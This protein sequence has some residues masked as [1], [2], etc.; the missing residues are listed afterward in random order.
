ML[1]QI[2]LFEI[3]YRLQRPATYI[4]FAI[5]FGFSFLIITLPDSSVS[6]AGEQLHKNAP[7][8]I[9]Q[10]VST[11]VLFGSVILAGVMGVPVYR[12][13]DYNFNEIVFSLPIKKWEYLLGKFT[14]SYIIA[15]IIHLGIVFGLMLGTLMPWIDKSDLGPF[16]LEAYI[17]P[18]FVFLLPNVFILGVVFFTVGALTRSQLAIYAQGLIFIV[19][20]FILSRL[21]ENVDTNPVNSVFE[22]FGSV[23]ASFETKYWTTYERNTLM[24]PFTGYVLLN[25]IVWIAFA[26]L[27]G[28]ICYL[29]FSPVPHHLFRAKKKSVTDDHRIPGRR[30]IK[31]PDFKGDY[32]LRAQIYQWWYFSRFH[33]KKTI[34]AIPFWIML[35]SGIGLLLLGRMG[36]NMLNSKSLPVTYML[37]NFLQGSFMIFTVIIIAIYSGELIW[38]DI[39]VKIS[40]VIDSTPVS[41]SL[42]V[43]SRFTAMVFVELFIIFF[44]MLTGIGIQISEGFFHFQ[45]DVYL[46]VLLLQTFPF[47]L[48]FTFLVFLVHTLINNKY[49][50]HT[51]IVALFLIQIFAG[52]FGLNHILTKYGTS[53][54]KSYSDMNR[55]YN[56]VFPELV[57]DFYWLMLGIVFLIVSVLFVK[58]G[59][60][61][62]F[63]ER[64][65]EMKIRWKTGHAKILIPIFLIMFIIS[66]SYIYYNTNILN[67]YRNKKADR[68]Y[69][70]AYERKYS[71]YK[72]YPQP[73]ILDVKLEADLY[74]KKMRCEM[75]GK[76]II[77]NKNNV[78]LDSFHVR[79]SP[80]ITINKLKFSIP[81][82]LVDSSKDYGY[83]IYKLDNPMQPGDT[84]ELAFDFIYQ[85]RGFNHWGH[86]TELVYNGT[87]LHQE[88]VPSFGYN[89]EQE[90][91][92]KKDRKKEGLPEKEF[93][94][95]EIT[96]TLA[97]KN[98]YISKN[99]DR[100]SYECIISTDPDQMAISAGDLVDEWTENGRRYFK[101]KMEEPIWN[102][103]PFFSAKYKVYKE[104]YKGLKIAVY[105]HP[106][107]DY[108]I[109]TMVKALKKTVDFCNKNYFPFQHDVLR[110]VEFPRYGGY[111]QSFASTIAFSEGLGFI[112]D[113]D[114]KRDID[115]PFFVTAHEVA[116]QWW[117]H[118]I[119]AADVKG[120]TLMVESLA[121]YT[122]LMVMLEELGEKQ[123]G[124]FL[125]YELDRYMIQRATER[126]KEPPL[127][128]VDNQNYLSYQKGG[129]AFYNLQDFIG[130]DSLHKALSRFIEK[131]YYQDAP[132][133]TSLDLI[134]F[135]KK[136]VP[137]SLNYIIDDWFMNITLYS[138][139]TDS[140]Y[141]RETEEGKYN[142]KLYTTSKK[143]QADSLGKQDALPLN[144][145]LDIGVYTKG[146]DNEDSLI[147]LKKVLVKDKNEVFTVEVNQKPTKAGIDPLNKQIDRNLLD[148]KKSVEPI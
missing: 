92:D 49:V 143:Y 81:T 19:L 138:N 112:L 146:S 78:E 3:K 44:I 66:G 53:I 76:Y 18:V 55:L 111:A 50:G 22:P 97:I 54:E 57:V 51:L 41:D 131:Y 24:L 74:P 70:A 125:K 85:E 11:F 89:E 103:Y 93:E 46:K 144:D 62:S 79:T 42:L 15:V 17:N 96:D 106:T 25:R 87:F 77:T 69:K 99:A 102:F 113:I 71:K 2:I 90:I 84:I 139:R 145:W 23:A 60:F 7:Y 65:M 101:Y 82:E 10:L 88:F 148:N 137:D 26:T 124:K 129:L 1:L 91:H 48:L 36:V 35:A 47:M 72:N 108:N 32:S 114:D 12:E 117:G 9:S 119:C 4:Y 30:G 75:S 142:V 80:W 13:Y 40:P 29:A 147:Y 59:A 123:A 120:K 5:L 130:K 38:K 132:Y 61:S 100:I 135:V 37:L 133:P 98:T 105:Y 126:K 104:D 121:E 83:Y 27:I 86:S 118:Q 95:A 109:K 6:E 141:Y 115:V 56:F 73:R 21:M 116:H 16:I 127:Y 68:A 45:T 94:S 8:I 63:R 43:L 110:I 136:V 39:D 28:I 52:E 107:H 134:S 33:F 14:G 58:R 128:L 67:T 64:L 34:K 140:A 20:Y 31:I 122:A